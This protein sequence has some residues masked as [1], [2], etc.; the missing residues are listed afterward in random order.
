M[1]GRSYKTGDDAAGH[2]GHAGTSSQMATPSKSWED[3]AGR[4][5]IMG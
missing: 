2:R 4:V 5:G 1:A 3:L